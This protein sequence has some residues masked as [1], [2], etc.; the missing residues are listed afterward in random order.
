MLLNLLSKVHKFF[1]PNNVF[2]KTAK[3]PRFNESEGTKYLVLHSRGYVIAGVFT[4]YL[5]IEGLKI[6]FFVVGILLLKGSL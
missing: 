1:V 6:K 3:L 5:I 2:T 4:I